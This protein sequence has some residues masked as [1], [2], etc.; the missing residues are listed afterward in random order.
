MASYDDYGIHLGFCHS[1]Q[2]FRLLEL[3]QELLDLLTSE[4]APVLTLK[5][6][7]SPSSAATGPPASHAVLTTQ[8]QTFQLRQVQSSNSIFLLQ[9]HMVCNAGADAFVAASNLSVIAQCKA[10]LELTS[11]AT[12]PVPYLEELL[13]LYK[14]SQDQVDASY[15]AAPLA[16][17]GEQRSK[18]N[19][20]ADVPIS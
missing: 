1:Q 6:S 5:S 3:P 9:P 13:P 20:L 10:T 7:S 16:A 18:L 15:I 19:L 2:S 4:D 14:G 8:N 11:I 12:S 17:M